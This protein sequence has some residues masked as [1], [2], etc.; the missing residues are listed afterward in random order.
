MTETD[1]KI[2]LERF[3][4]GNT[5]LE[6]ERILS[7]FLLHND[8]IPPGLEPDKKLFSCINELNG[9]TP[10]QEFENNIESYIDSLDSESKKTVALH[11]SV[12]KKIAGIAAAVIVLIATGISYN[13]YEIKQKDSLYISREKAYSEAERALVLLSQNLNKG[14]SK[15]DIA[16]KKV[17]KVNEII[18]KQFQ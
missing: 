7:D 1:I 11:P 2:L 8:N 6:E 3:Y 10:T 16:E 17:D 4:D 9:T 12:W 15:V 13:N 14:T 5:T 18:N